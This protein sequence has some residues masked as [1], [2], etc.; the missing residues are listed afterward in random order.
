VRVLISIALLGLTAAQQ[1]AQ[2]SIQ[3]QWKSP[4]G[5]SIIGIAP[6]GATLCGTVLWASE[7][8]KQDAKKG[9]DQLVG[10]QLLTNLKA[11]GT[12]WQGRLF[13]PDQNMRATAKIELVSAQQL[14]VSG[15]ALGKALCKSSL[16][17]RYD[18]ALPTSG[19]AQ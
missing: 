14:R 18:G 6:C 9:T 11:K 3:G 5:N 19:Q 8:A 15:C 16:W 4:G 13:V 12:G 7:K 1:P 2:P 17:T 10:S